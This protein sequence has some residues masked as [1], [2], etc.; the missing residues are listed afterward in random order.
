VSPTVGWFELIATTITCLSCK[1]F[2]NV[3]SLRVLNI[4]VSCTFVFV[5]FCIKEERDTLNLL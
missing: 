3:F 1:D 5:L 4:G 2:S